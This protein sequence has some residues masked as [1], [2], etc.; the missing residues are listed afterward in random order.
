MNDEYLTFGE[1]C[2]AF[3]NRN[4]GTIIA[5]LVCFGIGALMVYITIQ[6]YNYA[7]ATT[8]MERYLILAN[9]FTIPGVILMCV[10]AL[11]WVSQEG[12]FDSLAYA[13]RALLRMFHREREHIRYYDYVVERREKRA[14]KRS[15]KLVLFLSGL[16]YFAFAMLFTYL[17]YQV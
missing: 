13:G 8:D 6:N 16:F 12:V 17:Y 7:E 10:G 11:S 14:E 15:N 5:Y 9:A 2:K 3:W 1:R 4:S